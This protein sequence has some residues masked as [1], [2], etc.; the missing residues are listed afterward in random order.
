MNTIELSFVATLARNTINKWKF[1]TRHR[2]AP[3]G[4][5]AMSM[6]SPRFDH[7]VN[8]QPTD[9]LETPVVVP[10]ER[11][12]Q[13]DSLIRRVESCLTLAEDWDAY[14][15]V[16]AAPSTVDFARRL[17]QC[18]QTVAELP[19]PTS[20]TPISTG[21]M[22]EWE[23]RRAKL[24]FEIDEDSVLCVVRSKGNV[25]DR[26]DDASFD[27]QRAFAAVKRLHQADA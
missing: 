19:P 20:C 15:G 6:K 10:H 26:Y 11:R 7:D 22:L 5:R 2:P 21:L 1:N 23:A 12:E 14:G 4:D 9:D 3:P 25:L 16:P 8:E 17:L 27:V 13:F 18:V 24:Y